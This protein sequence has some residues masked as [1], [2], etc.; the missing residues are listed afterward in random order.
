MRYSDLI[1]NVRE[2]KYLSV[3]SCDEFQKIVEDTW[4]NRRSLDPVKEQAEQI[5]DALCKMQIDLF[6]PDDF[7]RNENW[8]E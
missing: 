3:P 2:L 6:L 5:F 1:C 7:D 8:I 4:Y